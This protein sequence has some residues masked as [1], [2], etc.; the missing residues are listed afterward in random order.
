MSWTQAGW[1]HS[2]VANYENW[3]GANN[4]SKN[5]SPI[6][7]KDGVYTIG[8]FRFNIPSSANGVAITKV[9]SLWLRL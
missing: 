5:V 4:F 1:N 7:Y 2:S 3:F 9:R 6:G 8:V